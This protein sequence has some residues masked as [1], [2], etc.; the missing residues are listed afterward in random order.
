MRCFTEKRDAQTADE[1]WFVQH[2]KVFTQGMSCHSKPRGLATIPVVKTDRGGQLTYHGPGQLIAYVLIDLKRRHKG[3]KWLVCQLE[4][5]VIDLLNDFGVNAER[6]SGAPGVYIGGSKIAA[7]G[8]R[9][10]NGASYHG[11]SLNVDMD[12]SP[13]EA[14][15]PCGFKDLP[16]TQLRNL[17]VLESIEEIQSVWVDY[18]CHK[19][20]IRKRRAQTMPEC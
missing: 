6:K 9:V 17:N 4:Q 12:L 19:L 8:L 15:D 20:K 18:L 13:Y 1:I 7:L 3:P 11:V 2:P 16:V 10:K 5:S 14:I